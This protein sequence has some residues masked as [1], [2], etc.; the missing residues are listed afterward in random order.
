MEETN[1][2]NN[3]KLALLDTES[4]GL[5]EDDEVLEIAIIDETGAT[6]LHSYVRPERHIAWP[7]AER[8]NHISPDMVKDAP[9]AAELAPRVREIFANADEIVGYNVFFDLNLLR[10]WDVNTDDKKHVD[11]MQIFAAIY[12]DWNDYFGDYQWKS[13][14][15]AA[16]YYKLNDY[17]PHDALTDV[18][19]TLYVYEHIL[20]EERFE[21]YVKQH[22]CATVDFGRYPQGANGEVEPIKWYVLERENGKAFLLCKNAIDCR[23]YNDTDGDPDLS[24]ETCTL[25][26]WL[27]NDFY[28]E[29]FTPEEQKKILGTDDKLSLLDKEAF[30]SLR[31]DVKP[32]MPTPWAVKHGWCVTEQPY[33]WWLSSVKT[34]VY[35]NYKNVSYKNYAWY[36]MVSKWLHTMSVGVPFC[37]RPVMWVDDNI[38]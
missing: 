19:A 11:V 5:D 18:K 28:N 17:K 34:E 31:F 23:S 29:A 10:A 1:I 22:P 26:S 3:K 12:G 4:T 37:V 6:L 32:C 25:R 14:S 21:E 33:D 9:T 8:V 27:N 16:D 20:E 30:E 2:F 7:D 15:T 36:A 24:W 13:L 38:L 35:S